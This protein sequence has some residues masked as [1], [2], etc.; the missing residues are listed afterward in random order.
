[1]CLKYLVSLL[2]TSLADLISLYLEPFEVSGVNHSQSHTFQGDD[3]MTEC[4]CLIGVP[5]CGT[6]ALGG[7]CAAQETLVQIWWQLSL[8]QLPSPQAR[9][10]SFEAPCNNSTKH[11]K[12]G[13]QERD[14][15]GKWT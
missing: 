5:L 4:F 1:M 10:R 7:P 14:E 13:T 6:E 8:F 12:K 15:L 9:E 11:R 2:Y 3:N